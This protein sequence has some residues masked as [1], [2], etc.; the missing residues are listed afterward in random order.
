[1]GNVGTSQALEANAKFAWHLSKKISKPRTEG[2]NK[3]PEM[4]GRR[5]LRS[6]GNRGNE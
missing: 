1:M 2:P 6:N 5:D 4:L 3:V